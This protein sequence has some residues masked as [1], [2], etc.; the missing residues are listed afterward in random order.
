MPVDKRWLQTCWFIL[1]FICTSSDEAI[2]ECAE[3]PPACTEFDSCYLANETSTDDASPQPSCSLYLAHSESIGT[4]AMFAGVDFE[5]GDLIGS[6]DVILTMLDHP[7][8]DWTLLQQDIALPWYDSPILHRHMNVSEARSPGEHVLLEPHHRVDIFSPAI[9]HAHCH[10][11][12][13]NVKQEWDLTNDCE[14]LD[15]QGASNG[16]VACHHTNPHQA[17]RPI[18]AG[19]QLFLHCVTMH[20][21]DVHEPPPEHHSMEWLKQ[22]GTCVD[23]LRVGPSSIPHA[24]R[25][26]F[27]RRFLRKGV[28]VALSPMLHINRYDLPETPYKQLMLNYCFGRPKSSHVFLPTGLAVNYINH[29]DANVKLVW[30]KTPEQ[31]EEEH[32][33]ASDR[34]LREADDIVMI[35]R[36]EALRDISAGEE[37][38]LDYGPEWEHAWQR[39][40]M[41][42]E[43]PLATTTDGGGGADQKADEEEKGESLV[44]TLSEQR[45]KPYPEQLTTACMFRHTEFEGEISAVDEDGHLVWDED[46]HNHCIRP[47]VVTNR[48]EDG[49]FYTA[50]MQNAAVMSHLDCVLPLESATGSW[51]VSNIPRDRVMLAYKAYMSPLQ[52]AAKIGFRHE[53]G[54]AVGL[55]PDSWMK[56]KISE[57][58]Y[59]FDQSPLYVGEIQ[60]LRLNETGK[61]I[62]EWGFR[63]GIP[64]TLKTVLLEYARKRGIVDELH[65]RV[66]DMDPLPSDGGSEYV[67]FGG[68]HWWETRF[69]G[70]WRTNM[71]YVTPADDVA[72][73]DYLEALGLA[74]FDSVLKSIGE[75]FKL[76]GLLCYYMS[77]IAVSHCDKGMIHADYDGTGGKGF[78]LIFP[79]MLV[80]GSGPELDLQADDESVRAGYHYR[81]DEGNIVGDS[82]YHGTA[83]CDYRGTGKMRLVVSI[84]MADVN[85]DNYIEFKDG[86]QDVPY[87][88]DDEWFLRRMG[89]HWKASDPSVRLKG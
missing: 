52:K 76:D 55:F 28:T 58:P 39:H 19:E 49:M 32:D 66:V 65:K 43:A 40:L 7:Y 78:N 73:D 18:A 13:P 67:Q 60:R 23:H 69:D 63:I 27:A 62:V 48:T 47:C 46:V 11:E 74:G 56:K 21:D 88:P 54:A 26:A 6:H 25:G 61:E 70:E 84:Y 2:C 35:A 72:F 59:T 42:W 8:H 41:T 12:H 85:P 50:I 44:R 87:P 29:G 38:L 36:Y 9:R 81:F 89:A 4:L 79:L 71:H 3:T 16:A 10:H 77:F 45:S 15:M 20:H 22:H 57:L 86:I 75:H 31:I 64:S 17:E 33:M 83:S 30:D 37:I 34:V 53:I 1:V 82:A 5:E 51:E 80:D 14:D 68:Y 24:G